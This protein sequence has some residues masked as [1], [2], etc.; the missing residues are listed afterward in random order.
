MQWLIIFLY[1]ILITSVFSC[2]DSTPENIIENVADP[3]HNGIQGLVLDSIFIIDD[4]GE[5]HLFKD[6]INLKTENHCTRLITSDINHVL[7]H[8]VK[9]SSK[10]GVADL[11][12]SFPYLFGNQLQYLRGNEI[13]GVLIAR[14]YGYAPLH[15]MTFH[16][17]GD[18]L[19]E[20][21]FFKA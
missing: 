20:I 7:I 1:A 8:S 2:D 5:K 13:N 4:S 9:V 3:H 11:L 18:R 21:G 16:V 15:I 6:I 14:L 12:T 19:I 17:S 10:S